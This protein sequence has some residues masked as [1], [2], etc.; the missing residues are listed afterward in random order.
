MKMDIHELFDDFI[1]ETV[2]IKSGAAVSPD[3]IIEL[4]KKKIEEDSTNMIRK[5][6]RHIP[7]IAAAAAVLLSATVF[8]AYNL[9]SPSEVAKRFEDYK[10]AECLKDGDVKFDFEPQVSGGY[11]FRLLGIVSGRNLGEFADVSKDKSYIIGAISREDGKELTEYPDIMVTPL[12][13]G[14]KPWEVNAFTLGNSGRQDFIEDGVDYF[15]FECDNIEIFADHTIYIAAY[16]GMA[17]GADEFTIAEDGSISFNESYTG[18]KA[19]FIVPIDKSKA[20]PEAVERFISNNDAIPEEDAEPE[21]FKI[22]QTET[23]DGKLVVI[24]DK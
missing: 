16:E 8:A 5:K 12:V 11:I 13:S 18:A 22:T 10:L 21:D 4:T 15:I 6:I 3:R 17:P 20:N 9:M 19:M 23:E 7:L 1:D 2:E 14:F 24:E